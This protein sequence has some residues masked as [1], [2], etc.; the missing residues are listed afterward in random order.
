[1]SIEFLDPTHEAEAA[2]VA[3]AG[4]LATLDGATV[5]IISNGKK[6]TKPFFDAL[7]DELRDTYKVADVVR[8]TKSNYSAPVEPER[9]V[10]AEKW[11][12]IISGIGD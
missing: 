9:L 7:A 6:N 3:S 8:I 4:R 2:G 1:M 10:E 11:Q 12:A 5:A